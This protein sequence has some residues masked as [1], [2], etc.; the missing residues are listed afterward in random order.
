MIELTLRIVLT[1][2]ATFFVLCILWVGIFE[3]LMP[4]DDRTVW[5]KAAINE[6]SQGAERFLRL[7]L[8]GPGK[9]YVEYKVNKW[10]EDE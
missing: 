9:L 6:R 8:F 4:V 1:W 10:S 7:F 5:A 2:Y 3:L